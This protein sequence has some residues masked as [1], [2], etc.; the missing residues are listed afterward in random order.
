MEQTNTAS[1]LRSNK[2]DNPHWFI[3]NVLGD[4]IE[5]SD[6]PRL[7]GR[8]TIPWV[9]QKEIIDS[10]WENKRTCVVASH[11]VGK[12]H[13]S[14]RISLAFLYCLR[15]S[16]VITT[17]PKATQVRT[18]L[19]KQIHAAFNNARIPLGGDLLQ[20]S[21]SP[22]PELNPNWFA[23]GMTAKD[24]ESFS[25]W[26]QENILIIIDEASGVEPHIYEAAEGI[27]SSEGSRI[28]LIGNPT[29]RTG[30]YFK[31][32]QSSSYH[33]IRI[34]C[35]DHPNVVKKRNYYAKAVDKDWPDE[36]KKE[37]GPNSPMFRVRVLGKFPRSDDNTVLPLDWLEAAVNRKVSIRGPKAGGLDVARFGDNETV[38]GKFVGRKYLEEFSYVGQRETQKGST[39]E[40][41]IRARQV[42]TGLNAFAIDDD[43]I[44]GAVVDQFRAS[45]IRGI[46]PFVSNSRAYDPIN[47]ANLITEAFWILRTELENGFL[48]R[49]NPAVGLSLPDNDN[50]IHQLSSRLYDYTPAGQMRVESKKDLLAR[51]EKSPDH[52]D[53]CVIAA[54]CRWNAIKALMGK[55]GDQMGDE[56]PHQGRMF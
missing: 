8:A 55:T 1:L 45:R 36:R 38:C 3:E 56:V 48:D 23:I 47:F 4:R 9:K 43:G 35:Y 20:V 21:L 19:W 32:F 17:A 26:H 27:L 16:I 46:F 30:E 18:I 53:C 50:L 7:F 51:E 29:T 13:I 15:P 28:L 6:D 42:K 5:P 24:S 25:G 12:S 54:W 44:G 52:G 2:F 11:N 22:D 34:N 41:F 39:V 33:N 49:T 10:V 31:A 40:T 37:W 14:G